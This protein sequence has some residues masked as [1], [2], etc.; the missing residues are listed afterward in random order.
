MNT[1]ILILYLFAVPFTKGDPV[2]LQMVAQKTLASCTT[3]GRWLPGR[4][5]VLG[6]L[7]VTGWPPGLLQDDFE[8]RDYQH[9]RAIR[10]LVTI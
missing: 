10:A 9:H 2:E 4:R 6:G 7:V 1:Y 8:F 5:A 3:E